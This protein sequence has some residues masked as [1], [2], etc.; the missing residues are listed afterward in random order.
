MEYKSRHEDY[1]KN[2][3]EA[4]TLNKKLMELQSDLSSKDERCSNLEL[5]NSKL[6]QRCEVRFKDIKY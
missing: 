1:L 5:Q 2:K 3:T 4:H 6:N